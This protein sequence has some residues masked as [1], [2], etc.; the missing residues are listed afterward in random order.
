MLLV[1]IA[2]FL[3]LG[4]SSTFATDM[5]FWDNGTYTVTPTATDA[6][7]NVTNLDPVTFTIDTTNP[8]INTTFNYWDNVWYKWSNVTDAVFIIKDQSAS[9]TQ[10]EE[11]WVSSIKFYIKLDWVNDYQ[12]ITNLAT[13]V[14]QTSWIDSIDVTIPKEKLV[15]KLSDSK[16]Y[17][18]LKVVVIDKTN[19]TTERILNF[20]YDDTNPV[21]SSSMIVNWSWW[22][23]GWYTSDVTYRVTSTDVT[24]WPNQIIYCVDTTNTCTP[25]VTVWSTADIVLSSDSATNYA[26]WQVKDI[27]WNTTAI[28]SSPAIK[29]DHNMPTYTSSQAWTL[30]TNGWYTS[31]VTF[32]I[33]AAD[34]TSKL[35]SIKYCVDQ[36]WTCNPDSWYFI[37]WALLQDK[38]VNVT[39]ST[40]S[41]KNYVVWKI[42]DDAWL[43]VSDKAWPIMIDK[44]NPSV[45]L[46]T[47]LSSDLAS[48]SSMP[49]NL[50]LLD[51][52]NKTNTDTVYWG[53]LP[54]K[55]VW[56]IKTSAWAVFSS[57]W[58][59]TNTSVNNNDFLNKIWWL[60]IAWDYTFTIEL[61]DKAW[62]KSEPQT[63][64]FHIYPNYPSQDNSTL[65]QTGNIQPKYANNSDIYEYE[66]VL[67]DEYNNLIYDS[68]NNITKDARIATVS[69]IWTKPRIDAYD[70]TSIVWSSL[71]TTQSGTDSAWKIKFNLKSVAPW[72]FDQKF[73]ITLDNWWKDYVANAW[74]TTITKELTQ[75][76]FKK[77]F[78]WKFN[79]LTSDGILHPGSTDNVSLTW[80]FINDEASTKAWDVSIW[81]LSGSTLRLSNANY[82]LSVTSLWISKDPA[83]S[84]YKVP[85]TVKITANKASPGSV[86]MYFNW[87]SNIPF[88][89]YTIDRV[90]V[91]YPLSSSS[92]SV[93]VPDSNLVLP[94]STNSEY[95]IPSSNIVFNWL[96]V[97]WAYQASG[98]STALNDNNQSNFSDLSTSTKRAEIKKSAQELIMWKTAGGPVV[99]WVKYVTWDYI[100]ESV[101][102][103]ETL[104]VKNWNVLI[105][106]NYINTAKSK[107]W[108][109]VMRDNQSDTS[110]WNIYVS[111]DV[112]Y[113]NALMYAD[114]W[115]MAVKT[116]N[117][118]LFTSSDEE[119]WTRSSTLK[120]QLI[121]KWSLFTRN[122]I[123]WAALENDLRLPGGSKTTEFFKALTYDLN[124]VRRGNVQTLSSQYNEWKSWN[125]EI[126]YNPLL[127]TNPPKW[128][129]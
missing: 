118:E 13:W 58:V 21:I 51:D 5:Y 86:S 47:F 95:V 24:S 79:I 124:Y 29:I 113:I 91:K 19:H 122:T 42:Y 96:N 106:E 68:K 125:L 33:N 114:W 107:L 69:H 89:T 66:V 41:N 115:L 6:A 85:G 129:K 17:F 43:S 11:T 83:T 78:T 8:S 71:T 23:N 26:R 62:N 16:S 36:A 73:E 99:W 82:S 2:Q 128:F 64:S 38:T 1:G 44:T 123:W 15:T 93:F 22:T 39:V 31:D 10:E 57:E 63:R 14:Q 53:N 9:T 105:K 81:T 27:A 60:T 87:A 50:K 34:A 101:P 61:T 40:E 25:N 104:I 94:T 97:T 121:I 102:T 103:Y 76:S 119:D 4:W 59:D 77:P 30:W 70:D 32:T 54:V 100:L 67:R 110:K 88:V 108:I 46:D 7:W 49:F 18:L 52:S 45:S 116:N 35:N 28:S 98:N 12:D 112:V 80:G 111:P 117:W 72:V 37:N 65:T 55:Y 120:N 92:S 20:R 109:I 90:T 126:I 127:Q 75:N 84:I 56:K 3:I 48:D 74:T